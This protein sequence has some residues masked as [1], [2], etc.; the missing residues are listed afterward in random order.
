MVLSRSE[1]MARIRSRDTK[2]EAILRRLLWSRG[3]R[4]RLHFR[5]GRCRP[6][7]VFVRQKALVFI[8]GCFWHGCPDHYVR[9]RTRDLFWR[10]KLIANVERDARQTRDLEEQGWR[11]CRL[12]EH[13][14][15]EDPES[16]SSKIE[17][18]VLDADWRPSPSWRVARVDPIVGPDDLEARHLRELRDRGIPRM[19]VRIRSTRKWKT[20]NSL[21]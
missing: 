1:Q 20:H 12:W 3:Y 11:V 13:E 10:T 21:R 9:P 2:P 8:D 14:I 4:Y 18:A 17:K 5:V 6:D 16:A 19:E 15:F 7:L